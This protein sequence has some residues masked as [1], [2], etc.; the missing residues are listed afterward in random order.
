MNKT[1]YLNYEVNGVL[2]DVY[3]I[4][5]GSSDGSYGIKKADGTVI[6][7]NNTDVSH[8]ATGKYE[9]TF[10]VEVGSIYRVSWAIVVSS[11][12]NTKYV[13]EDIGPFYSQ[14][15]SIRA[16]ADFKGRFSVGT[17][18]SFYL[19]I[20]NMDGEATDPDSITLEIKNDSGT[21]VTDDS[22]NPR[23][24]TRYTK[25]WYSYDW[26]IPTDQT[27]G[28]YTLTW[29]YTINGNIRTLVQEFVVVAIDPVVTANDP[30]SIKMLDVREAL[31]YMITC[32]QS[33]PVYR[34]QAKA[35]SDRKTFYFSFPRWNQSP[36]V[37][38]YRN[39]VIVN[40]G[41]TVDYFNGKI[42]FDN[43]QTTYD[44]INA[45]YNFR[46]FDDSAIDRFL[47]NSLGIYN[48]YPPY[49]N[50]NLYSIPDQYMPLVLYGAAVDAFRHLMLCL[51]FQQP[52]L[53]FGGSEAAQK[54]FGNLDSLKKNYEETWNKGLEQKKLG[55]YVGLTRLIIHP[56]FNLPSSKSRFFRYLFSG[57]T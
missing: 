23:Y 47:K 33:I 38:I 14:E 20:T 1:V 10:P 46:W 43:I 50:Y 52:Q 56:A 35:S 8:T 15:D 29:T 26:S 16:V 17:I 45:D 54:V 19:R 5:I 44:R 22:E 30:N 9:Y 28:K 57:S 21:T 27:T 32:A 4:K 6:I 53:V 41:L 31:G 24:P 13:V 3:S 49:S 25:G 42:T 48:M 40:S 11:G 39:D 7:A 37:R 55:S 2:T 34:E 51:Q 18:A 12:D 36:G